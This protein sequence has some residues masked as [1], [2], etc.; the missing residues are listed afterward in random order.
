M[1]TQQD[2][3]QRMDEAATNAE[4]ATD[5]YLEVLK[6]EGEQDINL[7]DGT[8]TPNLNKRLASVAQAVKSVNGRVGDVE[9]TREDLGIPSDE[10]LARQEKEDRF[11]ITES[12]RTQRE[13]NKENPS[14][15]DFNA[16]GGG[17]VDDTQA[18]ADL[19]V[20]YQG[21]V[22]DLL[23]N[24]YLVDRIPTK[25]KYING[26]FVVSG[27]LIKPQVAIEVK[28]L[29]DDINVKTFTRRYILSRGS[30]TGGYNSVPQGA[31]YDQKN[32]K[33][34][35]VAGGGTD[36]RG[37]SLNI[38]EAKTLG[39]LSTYVA[40]RS[41]RFGHQGVGVSYAEDGSTVV[42]MSRNY[43]DTPGTGNKV[44][45]FT[46]LKTATTDSIE[47][48]IIEWKLFD[49]TITYQSTTPCISSCGRYLVARMY[50]D[51]KVKV[52]VFD[53][54]A[55]WENRATTTDY[56]NKYISEFTYDIPVTGS[57]MQGF[58]CDGSYIYSLEAVYGFNTDAWV[59][60]FTLGGEFVYRVNISEVG[61]QDAINDS[62]NPP[63]KDGVK[64]YEGL[65]IFSEGGQQSLGLLLATSWVANGVTAKKAYIYE[66]G[67]SA[68]SA[69]TK[70]GLTSYQ[71]DVAAL[72]SSSGGQPY[73]FGVNDGSGNYFWSVNPER[74]GVLT[75][76]RNPVFIS[77][78]LLGGFQTVSNG[79]EGMSN[80]LLARTD[81]SVEGSRLIFHKSRSVATDPTALLSMG[82]ARIG[83]LVFNGD[84]TTRHA[85][86][87]VIIAGGTVAGDAIDG[88]IE[89]G[90]HDGTENRVNYRI[91]KDSLFPLSDNL[92]S[93][94]KAAN[95]WSTVHAGTGT[96]QTSDERL[97]QQFRSQS[98]REKDAALEIK[99]SIYL[100]KFNDAV[101]LKGDGARWHVGVKA[102][103]V[104]SI[105]E[106][107]DLNPFDYGFVCFDEWGEQEE[108][109][110]EEGVITQDRREAGSRYAIRYDELSMFILSSI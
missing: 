41:T 79:A 51:A 14:P 103:Q 62:P 50:E 11:V 94:G 48:G 38:F 61:L 65:L 55:M 6:T 68:S 88:Y 89:L 64:E 44:V 9:V 78:G 29:I 67:L 77:D 93:L 39:N 8:T 54:K 106:S 59:Y 24:T 83:S 107:H 70:N 25:N 60:V 47:T 56:S 15:F 76:M 58:A 10:I 35:Q 28:P 104:I 19:E 87:A 82:T 100:F 42:W 102:Q 86:G 23:N 21:Q 31:C 16:K 1:S 27:L 37:H 40:N 46:D 52:R 95:R 80:I 34:Y 97:K 90:V 32:G 110:D 7:P 75:N 108:I 13:K 73:N 92:K 98:D 4:H 49:N 43:N 105:L 26:K 45:S 66:I 36:G 84:A 17:V 69:N 101:D 20:Q 74:K 71:D 18:F 30:A 109:V 81:N 12:G 63:L 53:V 5:A 96:I 3:L 22:V 85:K 72:H 2:V 91:D 57:A 99:N 33:I